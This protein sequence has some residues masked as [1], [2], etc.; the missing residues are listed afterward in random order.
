MRDHFAQ[1]FVTAA[2]ACIG[3]RFRL[4][5]RDPA[6]GLDCIGLIVWSARCCGLVVPDATDYLLSDNPARLDAGLLAAPVALIDQRALAPG[7]MVRLLSSGQPLH[8]AICGEDTLIHADIRCRKVVEQRLTDD[9]R[10]R[11]TAAY[12]FER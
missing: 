8:L 2:R 12:R 6:T 5:G 4:Q 10:E 9:W 7:D 3:A 11:I 1:Q